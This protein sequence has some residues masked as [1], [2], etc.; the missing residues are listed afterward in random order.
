[1]TDHLLLK[2]IGLLRADKALSL[3]LQT[4]L[5]SEGYDLAA[6]EAEYRAKPYQSKEDTE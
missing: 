6:L 4:T 5:L 3:V 1:M 2:A